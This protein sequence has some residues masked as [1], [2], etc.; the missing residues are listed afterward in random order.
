MAAE[1]PVL[2]TVA[3]PA[4]NYR[5]FIERAVRSAL[6]QDVPGLRVLVVDDAST[7]GTWDV[8]QSLEADNLRVVR[9]PRN[10]GLFGNFN[11]CLALAEG[12]YVRLLLSDDVLPAGALGGEVAL[13]ERHADVAM[14][15]SSGLFID[16]RGRPL[17][18]FADDFPPGIYDGKAF[19]R[20]WLAY[21]V[22][23]R[24]NA[25]NYPSG[26]L[27][28]R[29][30]IG[31][32]LRF[33]ESLRTA[34]DVDFFLRLLG[35]GNLAIVDAIGC[36]VTRHSSQAHVGPNLDGTAM[37]EHYSLLLKFLEEP[38]NRAVKALREQ[39]AGMCLAVAAFRALRPR[40][41]HS[42]RAHLEVARSTGANMAS[43]VL[44]ALLLLTL[45]ATR[46][47]LR[48]QAPFI[49]RPIHPL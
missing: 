10:L 26:V 28:R 37:R 30:S 22:H 27:L 2:C 16:A 3:I 34:G 7:D 41:W 14:L 24:R 21:Y 29:A 33:D 49:P 25:F 20:H 18:R 46:R 39:F 19:A 4:Y 1:A 12:T 35:R 5:S 42:A 13:M 32:D 23:Y 11:R 36:H 44:R 45:R 17:R 40:T 31:A 47:V 38:R 43:M 15:N 9:N 48:R 6:A 8:L